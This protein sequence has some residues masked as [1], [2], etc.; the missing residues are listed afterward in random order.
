M[1]IYGSKMAVCHINKTAPAKERNRYTFCVRNDQKDEKNFRLKRSK[2]RHYLVRKRFAKLKNEETP[3]KV[4]AFAL[5]SVLQFLGLTL[6]CRISDINE[7]HIQFAFFLYLLLF[8]RK[9]SQMQ[10][11]T[12]EDTN[13]LFEENSFAFGSN[14]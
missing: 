2:K 12:L 9:K 14:T 3:D 8:W 4:S 7:L 5:D 13:T 11:K 10:K 6:K 1:T